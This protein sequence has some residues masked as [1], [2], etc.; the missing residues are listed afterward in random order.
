[1]ARQLYLTLALEA[2]PPPATT[3]KAFAVVRGVLARRGIAMPG[4][5]MDNGAGLSRAARVTAGGLVRLLAAAD[6]SDFR[7][8]FESSLAVA[9]VDGTAQARFRDIPPGQALLKTGTLDGVR[10]VAGYVRAAS[11]R[12]YALAAIVNDRN[13]A[14]AAGALEYVVQWV[15]SEG[16]APARCATSPARGGCP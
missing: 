7:D 15:D 6:R 3:A 5:A 4:L 14:Q 16:A 8:V 11:G 13:A 12:R 10:A 1:M 2:A 9:A